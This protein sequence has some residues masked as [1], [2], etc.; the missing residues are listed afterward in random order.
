M[1]EEYRKHVEERTAMGIPPRALDAEQTAARVELL[2][3]PSVG[4]EIS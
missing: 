1:L 2:K 4:G 3:T